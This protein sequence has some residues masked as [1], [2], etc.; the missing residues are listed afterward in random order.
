MSYSLALTVPNEIGESFAAW[1]GQALAYK[2]KK[3]HPVMEFVQ[4]KTASA[5]ERGNAGK[6]QGHE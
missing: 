6:E 4:S 1:V 3:L 2:T 5:P